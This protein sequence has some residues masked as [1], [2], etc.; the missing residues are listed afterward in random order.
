MVPMEKG[1]KNIEDRKRK[2][3]ILYFIL[4]YFIP[5]VL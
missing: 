2:E 3:N 4:V 1:E 5:I